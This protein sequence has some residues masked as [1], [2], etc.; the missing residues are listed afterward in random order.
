MKIK[1]TQIIF[2]INSS[3][4]LETLWKCPWSILFFTRS[5]LQ[6]KNYTINI[7][8]LKV[9]RKIKFKNIK[10][11]TRNPPQIKTVVDD[12]QK[13]STFCIFCS[14][15]IANAAQQKRKCNENGEQRRSNHC[16][17][18]FCSCLQKGIISLGWY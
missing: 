2:F 7:N 4:L 13:W 17:G 9:S 15:L 18:I 1:K 5:H 8:D 10:Q 11:Q 16:V 6:Q 14:R 3:K 12:H